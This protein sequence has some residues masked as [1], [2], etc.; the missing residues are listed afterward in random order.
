M[1]NRVN[2]GIPHF[3]LL[4]KLSRRVDAVERLDRHEGSRV[5]ECKGGSWECE[6]GDAAHDTRNCDQLAIKT[7][8]AV[9]KLWP[10]LIQTLSPGG[11]CDYVLPPVMACEQECGSLM[12]DGLKQAGSWYPGWKAVGE[13][14]ENV[15]AI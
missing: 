7:S 6:R 9:A 10:D 8:M 4:Q 2:F 14:M 11:K 13:E 1:Q 15:M 12:V 3:L 5:N